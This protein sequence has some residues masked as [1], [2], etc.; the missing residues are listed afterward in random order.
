[1]EGLAE[2]G[3]TAIIHPSDDGKRPTCTEQVQVATPV[4]TNNRRQ[5]AKIPFA[6]LLPMP[7]NQPLTAVEQ[8]RLTATVSDGRGKRADVR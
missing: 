1:M 4:A 6:D 7:R 5:H 3:T 2:V 8:R